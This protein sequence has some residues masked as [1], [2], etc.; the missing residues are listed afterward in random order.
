MVADALLQQPDSQFILFLH[1]WTVA[2]DS[3]IAGNSNRH[4]C[5]MASLLRVQCPNEDADKNNK[6]RQCIF[7][8]NSAGQVAASRILL[9]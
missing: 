4:G 5:S 7:F 8:S 6:E 1:Q 9:S 2:G 3:V